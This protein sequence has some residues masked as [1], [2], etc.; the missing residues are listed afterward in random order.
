MAR[1]RGR[2]WLVTHLEPRH[3]PGAILSTT[4]R[5]AGM[6]RRITEGLVRLK[7]TLSRASSARCIAAVA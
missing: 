7:A 1:T 5:V 4:W 3:P 6:S 2:C